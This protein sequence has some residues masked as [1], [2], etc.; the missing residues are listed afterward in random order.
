MTQK[1]SSVTQQLFSVIAQNPNGAAAIV[2]YK[3]P[4]Q[5]EQRVS[6][7][8]YGTAAV[9]QVNTRPSTVAISWSEYGHM[10]AEAVLHLRE[11]GLARGD[12]VAILGWDCLEWM[13]I[14]RAAQVLGLIV[15][16]LYPNTTT[17]QIAHILNDSTPALIVSE[18]E[19]LYRNLVDTT[20]LRNGA[21]ASTLFGE[22]LK[23][24]PNF[25]TRPA[26]HNGTLTAFKF[27]EEATTE[28][29]RLSTMF[30][31]DGAQLPFD[32][33]DV[34][35]LIYT[36]GSTS[37]PKGAMISHRNI[38]ASCHLLTGL[39]F[40]F[41]PHDVN[42]H[43]LPAAH[44]YGKCNGFELSEFLGVVSAFALPTAL[45]EALPLYSPT[46][47]LGVPRVYNR[48]KSEVE[49]KGN[50]TSFTAKMLR[51]GLRQK[52]P[53]I[54]RWIANLLVHSK[55]RQEL[56]M[57]KARMLVC[58]SAAI[59]A[60]TVDF[61]RTLGL[62]LRE[63]YGSTET[64]GGFMGNTLT[65]YKYGSLGRPGPG[66]E[67]R[68]EVRK[69]VDTEPNTGVLWVRGD[70]VFKGYWNNEQKTREAF[71]KDGWYCTGDV[72]HI[73]E[74][75]YGW[76]RGRAARQKKL[77][78][79]EFY[80]EELIETAL[81]AAGIVGSAV[82]TGEGRG[83]IGALIFIDAAVAKTIG[84]AAPAGENALAWYAKNDAVRAAVQQAVD[85]ANKALAEGGVA[86]KWEQVRKWDIVAEEPTV[87]NG[88]LTPTLKIK[89]E[90]VLK[91][92]ED[93]VKV[94]YER[95]GR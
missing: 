88:M 53:G 37:L 65:D 80:S 36:S 43:Y 83:C 22:V 4:D 50:G 14:N 9:Y 18:T 21:I 24:V 26:N 16:P 29:K 86:K 75:G 82:P 77:D 33:D 38:A 1:F 12:R 92:Y 23:H 11:R 91:R 45:K 61:F 31:T 2:P 48:F 68:L 5:F 40:D 13:V 8:P 70:F 74:D 55:I 76:F 6:A 35:T 79:G 15:V 20:M 34:C 7:T 52:K 87:D 64:C 71:D 62:E 78:T 66:A 42:L 51:W 72:V 49:K 63:G 58:G 19:K 41:G 46:V 85:D 28:F 57:T 59:P 3:G 27:R 32:A 94:M 89:N 69:D 73:D 81:T 67:I 25:A 60:D 39:G 90:A 17:D 95:V 54:S 84:G 93:I 56:G 47:M 44:I 10:V 30:T